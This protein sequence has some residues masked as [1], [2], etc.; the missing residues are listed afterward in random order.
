M[1]RRHPNVLKVSKQR[2]QGRRAYLTSVYSLIKV[3][4]SIDT[5]NIPE[6]A[7]ALFSYRDRGNSYY[8]PYLNA[9]FPGVQRTSIERK[10]SI[11]RMEEE[12]LIA[13][14]EHPDVCDYVTL[15]AGGITKTRLTFV[16][17]RGCTSCFF[18]EVCYH[19]GNSYVM[20]SKLYGSRERAMFDLDHKRITWL[21]H[22][23]LT[24][25]SLVLPRRG[26]PEE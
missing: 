23:P 14:L 18:L 3:P 5:A 13:L 15:R 2:R 10:F 11:D 1:A 26:E 7:R 4:R 22:L 8:D 20:K 12:K 17:N 6:D 19:P 21:E 16:F 9:I 24:S 25:L